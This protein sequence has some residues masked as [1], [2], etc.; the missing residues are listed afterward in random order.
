MGYE[1]IKKEIVGVIFSSSY[2]TQC[3]YTKYEEIF[4]KLVS[5]NKFFVGDAVLI[6]ER[7][8]RIGQ[9]DMSNRL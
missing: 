1:R 9:F 7:M 5:N 3:K 2:Y 4:L 6:T 8:V